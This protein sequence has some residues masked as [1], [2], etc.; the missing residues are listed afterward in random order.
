MKTNVERVFIETADN[1]FDHAIVQQR[2]VEA[3]VGSFLSQPAIKG[4]EAWHV[5]G[6]V[7]DG[8]IVMRGQIARTARHNQRIGGV[9]RK[10]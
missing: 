8:Q 5:D 2:A 3:T 6:W 9:C 4:G 1:L 7:T 10:R